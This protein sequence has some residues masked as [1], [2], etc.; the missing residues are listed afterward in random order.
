MEHFAN[1]FELLLLVYQKQMPTQHTVA[2]VHL[3]VHHNHHHMSEIIISVNL[4]I[5]LVLLRTQELSAI[6]MI[7]SG[8]RRDVTQRVS[9]VAMLTL[10]LGSVSIF[11]VKQMNILKYESVQTVV[12]TMKTLLLD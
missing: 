10:L 7:H 11:Q 3:L 2:H 6:L 1:I 9:V 5:H 12:L 4:E 8:M